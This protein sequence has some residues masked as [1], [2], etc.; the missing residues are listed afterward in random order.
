M[1][2]LAY[3]DPDL[4]ALSFTFYISEHFTSL[5]QLLFTET[6][7]T[8]KF[9]DGSVLFNKGHFMRISPASELV[10]LR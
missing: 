2:L 5:C 4:P 3:C 9:P 8:T 7:K 6:I 1:F 10:G